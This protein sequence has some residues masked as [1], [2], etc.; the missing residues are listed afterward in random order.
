[1]NIQVDMTLTDYM[2]AFTLLGVRHSRSKPAIHYD[3]A[4]PPAWLS[5]A[6]LVP[7]LVTGSVDRE[8]GGNSSSADNLAWGHRDGVVAPERLPEIEIMV[9]SR[10]KTHTISDTV[11]G[12]N[13]DSVA[14][15]DAVPA[16]AAA[17]GVAETVAENVTLQVDNS[18]SSPTPNNPSKITMNV[19][20]GIAASA[21]G[22]MSSSDGAVWPQA[23]GT[24]DHA[25]LRLSGADSHQPAACP[26]PTQ[27]AATRWLGDSVEC[28]GRQDSQQQ[29][30]GFS[31]CRGPNADKEVCWATCC[32]RCRGCLGATTDMTYAELRLHKE[33]AW[34]QF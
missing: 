5:L 10:C 20:S 21:P 16:A 15:M 14:V 27:G 9:C 18:L 11:A 1:M 31:K 24:G 23:A 32:L 19:T 4:L 17:A 12:S 30:G 26:S 22:A 28:S 3:N 6:S 8:G 33:T 2:A 25:P 7:N 13:A 34:N 29:R